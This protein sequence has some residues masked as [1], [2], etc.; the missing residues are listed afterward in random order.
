[1]PDWIKIGVPDP[2]AAECRRHYI[3]NVARNIDN[4][5]RKADDLS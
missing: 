5:A 1:V 3:D 2:R 4:L